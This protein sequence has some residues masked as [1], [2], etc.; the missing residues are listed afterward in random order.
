MI[1]AG[2]GGL[3]QRVDYLLKA[4]GNHLVDGALFS[5][6][7][8]HLVRVLPIVL[9]VFQCDE[10]VEVHKKLGRG[11]CTA[12]HTRHHEYHIDK[13]TAEALKVRRSLGVATDGGGAIE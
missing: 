9:A 2:T 11:A 5:G 8:Y 1:V 13:S 6:E 7:V 3:V 10:M 12:E 4:V